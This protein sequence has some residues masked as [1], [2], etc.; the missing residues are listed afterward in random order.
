MYAVRR[1]A[2]YAIM[3]S[4]ASLLLGGALVRPAH[5]GDFKRV[6]TSV[7]TDDVNRAAMAIKF[8]QAIMKERGIEGML[9]FNVYGVRLVNAATP[10][11]QYG[12]GE[13]IAAMLA[14]FI[15]DGGV[16]LACPMCMQH[17]GKMANADLLP[18]VAAEKG[19]GA[20]AM[21]APD[22]LALSY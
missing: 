21:S 14:A 13:T 22:T 1:I 17:V 9:F 6:V 16:V 19:A 20:R 7:T 3:F 10:S 15:K 5:A 4:L 8:T 11:P 12:N 2:L 18:G